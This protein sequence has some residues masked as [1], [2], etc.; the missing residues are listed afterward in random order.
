M[1][2]EIVAAGDAEYPIVIN[3]ARFYMYDMAEHGGW[4]FEPNGDFDVGDTFDPYWG[5]PR[6]SRAWPGDWQ[7]L[8]FLACIDGHPAGFAL[9]VRMN[10]A[11][12]RYDMGEFFVA[13]QYRRH[14]AGRRMATALFDR[15][16]GE[17]II[18]QLLTNRAAHTFWRRI[19]ADY[20]GGKF[21]ETWEHF[22][23]YGG[24]EFIV[25]RLDSR[26]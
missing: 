24:K 22:A 10:E 3:L 25:Q 5:R 20:T 4:P 2:V 11:S 9:V 26:H 21:T 7:G 17:W 16:A 8:P 12:P 19:I 13:R 18:R 1:D 23:E 14:G 6:A 15:F